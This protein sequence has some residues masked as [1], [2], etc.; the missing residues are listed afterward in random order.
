MTTGVLYEVEGPSFIDRQ[1]QVRVR[2]REA[3]AITTVSEILEAL[4]PAF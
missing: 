3:G 1:E 2:A 4:A